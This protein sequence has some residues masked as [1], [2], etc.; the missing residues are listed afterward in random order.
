MESIRKI[1]GFPEYLPSKQQEF[2][3]ALE[4]IKQVFEKFCAF[5]IATPAVERLETLTKKGGNPKEIYTLGRLNENGEATLGLK[6]DLT[7]PLAR[8]VSQH[9]ENLTFPFRRYQIQPVWRGERA[10]KARYRQFYQCDFDVVGNRNLSYYY[11]AEVLLI[12]SKIMEELGLKNYSIRL[13]HRKI[14]KGIL[15]YFG[16]AEEKNEEVF[17]IL[18][19]KQKI[20]EILFSEQLAYYVPAAQLSDFQSFLEEKNNESIFRELEKMA[21]AMEQK[22]EPFTSSFQSAL[23]EIQTIYKIIQESISDK[24]NIIFDLSIVRGLEYYTG[25]IFEVNLKGHSELG[26]ICSGGRYDDLAS[27]FGRQKLPG[28]GFSIGL[29]RLFHIISGCQ[30]ER[31]EKKILFVFL[32]EQYLKQN[33]LI[34]DK[35]REIGIPTEVFLEKKKILTQI[36]YAEKLGYHWVGFYAKDEELQNAVSIKNL[37][38]KKQELVPMD[39]LK[40]YFSTFQR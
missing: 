19:K 6:F 18:D 16:V 29:S 28:V 9:F 7:V 34:A 33:F 35:I 36:Q 38:T 11:D 40:D 2:Q 24:K 25:M 27:Y 30:K 26:S 20:P 31:L 39:K 12:V 5:P 4:K 37:Q 1:S 13:N 15:L 32:E 21:A 3:R 14:L 23:L 8:Y 10:Q 22:N 17:R